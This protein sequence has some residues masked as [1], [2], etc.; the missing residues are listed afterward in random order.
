MGTE[1]VPERA[2]GGLQR[3]LRLPWNDVL[4][5]PCMKL[6]LLRTVQGDGTRG[7][8]AGRPR[9]RPAGPRA[10]AGSLGAAPSSSSGTRRG[11]LGPNEFKPRQKRRE[12]RVFHLLR[13]LY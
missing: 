1:L 13:V 3:V 4:L 12:K 6:L 2:G 11:H 7:G 9:L 10:A 8:L 5:S